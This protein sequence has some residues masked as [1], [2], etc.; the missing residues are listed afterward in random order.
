VDVCGCGSAGHLLGMKPA[1]TAFDL[2]E[3][4]KISVKHY[5]KVLKYK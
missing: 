2:Y 3:N 1:E 5:L 4:T